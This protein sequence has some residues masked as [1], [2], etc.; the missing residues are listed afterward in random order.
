MVGENWVEILWE[1]RNAQL[2]DLL[3]FGHD[4]QQL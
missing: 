3:G 1:E 2:L 4:E